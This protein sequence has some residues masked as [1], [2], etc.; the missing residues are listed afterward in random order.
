MIIRLIGT[1]A[2]LGLLG[3]CAT[4]THDYRTVGRDLNGVSPAD[5]AAEVMPET[6]FDAEDDPRGNRALRRDF[7]Y[8]MMAASD[9]DC[10]DYLIGVAAVANQT[11]AG[12]GAT[13]LA[14]NTAGA[15][16]T[17]DRSSRLLNALG[18]L[19]GSTT[20]ALED[21]VFAGRDFQIIYTAVQT[22]RRSTRDQIRTQ[23]EAGTF[24]TWG[25]QSL[26]AL[27]TPYHLNCGINYG[28]QQIAEAVE[29]QARSAQSAQAGDGITP[30]P[31][32]GAAAD[33]NGT[34]VASPR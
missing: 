11:R 14:L 20:T 23:L 26:V 6:T 25:Y 31:A 7:V 19:T 2:C 28:L 16:A 33:A 29:I 18:A 9:V 10:E 24:D 12:F 34:P 3:G 13:G 30:S 1:V 27:V 8:G 21:T 5:L 22:G 4:L 32:A 15:L 17:P